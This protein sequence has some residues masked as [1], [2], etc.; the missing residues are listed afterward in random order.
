MIRTPSGETYHGKGIMGM[1]MAF[2]N[3][4]AGESYRKYQL[5][6]VVEGS[7]EDEVANCLL[8]FEEI[9]NNGINEYYQETTFRT[10]FRELFSQYHGRT[11]F[12]G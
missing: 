9:N 1:L 10:D 6:F 2:A 4:R 8:R 5:C 3:S 11:P 7:D 12:S